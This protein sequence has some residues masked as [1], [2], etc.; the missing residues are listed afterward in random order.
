MPNF[1]KKFAY[2]KKKQYLCTLKVQKNCIYSL[3][4]NILSTILSSSR[5]VFTPQWLAMVC[6]DRDRQS[7]RRS[8]QY[9]AAT[10]ALRNPRRGIYTK[11]K[12]D[13]QEMACALLKPSYIS[14]EYVLARI[15]VTF[16]YSSEISCISYQSRTIEVDGKN[17]SFRQMN[18]MIWANMLGIEQ[19]DNIAIATP[20]RAFLDM[21]YLSAGQ[22]YFDNLHPLNHGLIRQILPVYNSPILIKRVEA[23]LNGHQ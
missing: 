15:G 2:F 3:F 23:L 4:M 22:C 6:E 10:G 19:R 7:L 14:L 5:T 1:D 12:Y 13:E 16:Q 11:P 21:V 18:K 17:Y 20:E 9:Y 8:L